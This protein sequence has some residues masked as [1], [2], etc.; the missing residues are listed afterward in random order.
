MN[1]EDRYA[2]HISDYI[3]YLMQCVIQGRVEE[4]PDEWYD[5]VINELRREA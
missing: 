1:P 3:E 4:V 2:D 5:I